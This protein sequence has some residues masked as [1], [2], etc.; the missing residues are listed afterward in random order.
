MEI[1]SIY[2]LWCDTGFRDFVH[3]EVNAS[4]DDPAIRIKLLGHAWSQLSRTYP[5]RTIGWYRVFVRTS[6]ERH[7]MELTYGD[8]QL[9]ST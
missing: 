6:I 8:K 7:K 4:S 5:Q 2:E 1:E 9:V 3:R